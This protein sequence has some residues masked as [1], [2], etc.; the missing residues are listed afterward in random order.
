MAFWSD[1]VVRT[2]LTLLVLLACAEGIRA[3]VSPFRRYGLPACIIGGV[4]GLMLGPSVFDL[5][6]SDPGVLRTGV[7]HA[8]GVVF[9]ALSLQ[10]PSPSKSAA[11]RSMAF[12][13]TGLV[14]LQT[15][16]G[17]AVVL[18]LGLALRS[19][20]HPGLGLMQP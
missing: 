20:V 2:G 12:G 8:L 19:P 7:Y 5:L 10:A 1:P 4:L 16:V 14:A 11:G 6:P 13:I 9:I 3:L 17:L 18:V 15:A